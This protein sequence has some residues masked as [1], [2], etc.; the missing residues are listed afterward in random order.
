MN[1]G[2]IEV[3]E[4]D[5]QDKH[6]YLIMVKIRNMKVLTLGKYNEKRL[7]FEYYN[8]YT[9]KIETVDIEER[10]KLVGVFSIEGMVR[11]IEYNRVFKEKKKRW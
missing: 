1:I 4:V 2:L 11:D 9:D 5:Y 8:Y 6:F 3:R 10:K 7:I